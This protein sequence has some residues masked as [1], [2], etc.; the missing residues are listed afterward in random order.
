MARRGSCLGKQLAKNPDW[1][2]T[3]EEP[4]KEKSWNTL[5]K[6]LKGSSSKPPDETGSDPSGDVTDSVTR[7]HMRMAKR[8]RMLMPEDPR[9]RNWDRLV[10]VTAAWVVVITPMHPTIWLDLGG[11]DTSEPPCGWWVFGFDWVTAIILLVDMA[12][13][14][15]TA[16]YDK[17]D[18]FV[19]EPKKVRDR[20]VRGSLLF[21]GL[22]GGGMEGAPRPRPRRK[23]AVK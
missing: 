3:D 6:M 11:D 16:Y 4:N 21:T 20:S 17:D 2:V 7:E 13:S 9:L 15:R 22:A 12:V 1:H 14:A 19:V 23:L 5:S 18:A 8:L 10:L